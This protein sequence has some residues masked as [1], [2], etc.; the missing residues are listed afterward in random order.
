MI[1]DEISN[2]PLPRLTQ[3]LAESRGLGVS[4]CY[5]AQAG[6]RLDAVYR[7]LQGRAIRAVPPATLHMYGSHEKESA[8]VG[9][10]LGR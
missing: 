3:Y 7:P 9:G 2:T 10:V 6:K 8:G 5:A 1:L 4:I